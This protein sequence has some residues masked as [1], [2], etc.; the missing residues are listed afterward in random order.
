MDYVYQFPAVKGK[1]AKKEYYIAMV[2]LGILSKLFPNT[3]EYVQPEYRAQRRINELRIPEIT[4]Y[5]LNNRDNYVFSALSASIDGNFKFNESN[6]K[7]VGILN[8]SMDAKFLINDGQHRKTAIEQ[9][10]ALDDT[11]K[12]ETI[13]IVFFKDE[14]LKRSQQMFTDL[15]K[16]AVKTSNSIS[17]LYDF[18]DE[19]A[20]V[21]KKVMQEI[22]FFDKYIDKE[23]DNLGKNSSNL[24][25][26]NNLYKA[27]QKILRR[28]KISKNDEK[29]LIDYWSSIIS[30]ITEFQELENGTLYKSALREDYVLCL[31]IILN[32]FGRLG[33][34]VYDNRLNKQIFKKLKYIN[35]K[36]TNKEWQK[37]IMRDNGKIVNTEEAC[38]KACSY[39][40]KCLKLPLTKEEKEKN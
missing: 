24:F 40:K 21:S 37:R 13:S 8:V 17:N 31:A 23:R 15:N 19:L 7:N 29:F 5:I 36:R 2:P 35:W 26:F 28:K 33:G 4:N 38:I 3:D 1:Q 30:N 11:L 18:R 22:E 20:L 25:T 9:A 16:H 6:I 14:G 27:N 39:I 34:Y 12:S 32:A 10:L